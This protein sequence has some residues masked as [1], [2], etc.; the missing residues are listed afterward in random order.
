MQNYVA[1]DVAFQ[2]VYERYEPDTATIEQ[3][4]ALQPEAR[5]VTISATW[6]PDCRRNVPRWA[7]VMEQ[8]PG[9]EN[10]IYPREDE[11]RA[12]QLGI[13]AIPTFIIYDGQGKELGRVVENPVLGSLEADI[14]NIVR[15]AQE[16]QAA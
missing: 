15:A 14:L 16:E 5:V 8:L 1:S 13:R 12:K 6:C 7:R 10:E 9:W 11:A 4:R 3:I 2:R